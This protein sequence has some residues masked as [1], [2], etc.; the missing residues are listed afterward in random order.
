MIFP[1][2]SRVTS[3]PS[4]INPP[5]AKQV[6]A[7]QDKYLAACFINHSTSPWVV[8]AVVIPTKSDGIGITVGYKK[9]KKHSNIGQLPIPCVVKVLDKLGNGNMFSL[10]DLFL[11]VNSE[12]GHSVSH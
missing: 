11:T 6:D 9:L 7:I 10:F 1:N 2:S 3:R 4:C 8:L 5:T 12:N